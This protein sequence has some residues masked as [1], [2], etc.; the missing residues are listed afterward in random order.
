[1]GLTLIQNP[2]NEVQPAHNQ[3]VFVATSNNSSELNFRYLF[4]IYI[5]TVKVARLKVVPNE[6]TK[7]IC[8]ISRIVQD[9]IEQDLKGFDAGAVSGSSAKSGVS[10]NTTPHSIHHIDKF[11]RNDTTMKK[12]EVR[13]G[14]EYQTSITD[15]PKIYDGTATAG[16][17]NLGEPAFAMGTIMCWNA[18][19]QFL[20]G[21]DYDIDQFELDGTTKRFLTQAPDT[22]SIKK[23]QYHTISVFNGTQQ[24]GSVSM[25]G[26]T[27]F[28]FYGASGY[29]SG[30]NV[31]NNA[32]NGGETFGTVTTASQNKNLLVCGVGTQNL[33]NSG[34]TIPAA[35]TYYSVR[36]YA[37]GAYRSKTYT[38]NIDCDQKFESKRL[39]WLNSLG[40]WDY[41]NSWIVTGKHVRCSKLQQRELSDLN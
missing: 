28:D 36:V 12:I 6:N 14:E 27:R 32:T 30:F 18:A 39:A 17:D 3:L 22:Q 4:D 25:M 37:S 11:S 34:Q 35:A 26:S 23:G 8:D 5:D 20:D 2:T 31:I 41:Y 9:Y 21:I 10:A 7:G 13:G 24:D 40:G 16:G 38:F 19:T 15:T 33:V 1:M 29:I